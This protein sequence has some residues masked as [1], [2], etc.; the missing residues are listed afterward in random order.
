MGKGYQILLYFTIFRKMHFVNL[1]LH[2]RPITELAGY[3]AAGYSIY[4]LLIRYTARK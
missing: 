1:R 3:C 4:R 2:E